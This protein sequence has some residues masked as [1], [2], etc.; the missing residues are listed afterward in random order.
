MLRMDHPKDPSLFGLW[1]SG[2]SI[3]KYIFSFDGPGLILAEDGR[4]Y[5]DFHAGGSGIAVFSVDRPWV[6]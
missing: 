4:F 1:L 3:A 5:T 2:S 6:Q